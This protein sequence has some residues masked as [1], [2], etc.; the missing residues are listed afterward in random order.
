[1][2]L[3]FRLVLRPDV[4]RIDPGGGCRSAADA[5]ADVPP[6]KDGAGGVPRGGG[7]VGGAAASIEPLAPDFYAWING[8][9]TAFPPLLG[10]VALSMLTEDGGSLLALWRGDGQGGAVGQPDHV[11][12]DAVGRSGR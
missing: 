11:R 3:L 5:G 1:M 12:R 2:L 9:G 4:S 8:L 6:G 10:A 7:A